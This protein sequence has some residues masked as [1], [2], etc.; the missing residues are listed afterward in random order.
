LTGGSTT[1]DSTVAEIDVQF[2]QRAV[3]EFLVAE[4]EEL[5]CIHEC[6]LQ[7][8]GDA[9]IDVSAVQQLVRWIKEAG[10]GGTA[11]HGKLQSCHFCTAVKP[12]N[13][14]WVDELICSECLITTDELY[15][16]LS[17]SKGSVMAI[18]GELAIPRSVLIGCHEW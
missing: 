5:T 8:Y 13:I 18:M 1:V 4:D 16:T 12:H 9:A 7:V 17:I 15:S 10:T 6:L 2:K 11:L 14:W 3:V